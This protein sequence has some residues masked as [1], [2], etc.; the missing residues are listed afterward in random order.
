MFPRSPL[1]NPQTIPFCKSKSRRQTGLL[2][3]GGKQCMKQP[4]MGLSESSNI[5]G[6]PPRTHTHSHTATSSTVFNKTSILSL[7]QVAILQF[8]GSETEGRHVRLPPYFC[9][10]YKCL[11]QWKICVYMA[12]TVHASCLHTVAIVGFAAE[13]WER[14]NKRVQTHNHTALVIQSGC[15]VIS[16]I[17]PKRLLNLESLRRCEH[18]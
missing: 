13:A 5:G 1:K 6:E 2:A 9:N 3:H 10:K 11:S 12:S 4:R 14:K 7:F 17:G 15:T 8:W 18:I 16:I